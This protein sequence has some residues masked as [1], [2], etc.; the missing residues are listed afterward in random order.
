MKLPV[1]LSLLS[2]FSLSSPVF[3]SC[4]PSDPCW[5]TPAEIEALYDTLD[6]SEDRSGLLRTD[7]TK[8]GSPY[9]SGIPIYSQSDQPLYGYE[10]DAIKP[11]YINNATLTKACFATR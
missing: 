2:I 3:S 7:P 8:G 5:P 4:T 10:L 11:L 9:P 1:L 6:E